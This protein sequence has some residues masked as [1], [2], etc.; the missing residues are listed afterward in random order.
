MPTESRG[1]AVARDQSQV[2]LAVDPQEDRGQVATDGGAR[3]G[4][5][6][7][8]PLGTAVASSR[9]RKAARAFRSL[10]LMLSPEAGTEVPHGNQSICAGTEPGDT[11]GFDTRDARRSPLYAAGSQGTQTGL[12]LAARRWS[13]PETT[14]VT[15]ICADRR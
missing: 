12:L 11:V 13:A 2:L 3:D 15:P 6:V 9:P 7:R 8:H 4:G 10:V 5:D 14:S 1:T